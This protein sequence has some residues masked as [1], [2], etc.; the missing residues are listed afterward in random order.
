MGG[1]CTSVVFR[2]VGKIER[3]IV[4]VRRVIREGV[5]LGVLKS[6]LFTVDFLC[7][8]I[9]STQNR[10]IRNHTIWGGGH[11]MTWN[12]VLGQIGPN[13]N[14]TPLVIFPAKLI[15]HHAESST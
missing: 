2:R 9:V 12:S 1:V 13:T 15:S 5:S 7:A 11:N 14:P 3:V 10:L 4:R 6:N 8:E